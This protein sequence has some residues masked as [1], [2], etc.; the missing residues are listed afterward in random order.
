MA[1]SNSAGVQR[2]VQL[3]TAGRL[4]EAE[5]AYRSILVSNPVEPTCVNNLAALLQQKGDWAGASRLLAQ[6]FWFM[7]NHAQAIQYW[8]RVLELSPNDADT[9]VNLGAA[10]SLF[11][12]ESEAAMHFQRA[13]QIHPK[14]VFAWINLGWLMHRAGKPNEA[15]HCYK[16]ALG[17][18]PNN[19]Q[20]LSRL[21]SV[22]REA[23]EIDAA[24]EA[25][26]RAIQIEPKQVG[27]WINLGYSYLDQGD[28]KKAIE[29]FRNGLTAQ[30]NDAAARSNLLFAQ[31][32]DPQVNRQRLFEDHLEFGRIHGA[33]LGDKKPAH[34]NDRNTDRPLKIAYLS[35]D[36]RRHPVASFIEPVLRSHDRSR[37]IVS[38]YSDVRSGDE[39][40]K[41]LRGY[42][43]NWFDVATLSNEELAK[44][45][46]E[47]RED[48]L[49]D[50]A[51]H[52]A[53]GRMLTLLQKPAPVQ[54]TYLGYLNT[55]GLDTVD[56]RITD[57]VADPEPA[58]DAYYSEKLLRLPCFFCY[59][60]PE[61]APAVGSLPAL[62]AGH[63]TFGSLNQSGKFNSQVFD[64]WARLLERVPNSRLV[65]MNAS[66]HSA[67]RLL[68]QF[69]QRGVQADR[70][71]LTPKRTYR[72][73]LELYNSIDIAL[74]PFPFSGH[75]TTCDALWMGCPVI[76]RA[77]ELYASRTCASVLTHLGLSEL[78][79]NDPEQYL[80]IAIQ[81]ANDIDRLTNLRASLRQRM[82]E[83]V[84]TNAAVFTANLERELCEVWRRTCIPG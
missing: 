68:Q 59:Q 1:D 58:A 53:G 48:I 40:T 9:H 64:L 28:A 38:C 84:I 14:H 62:S 39:I 56:Y 75:T 50:L 76:T 82:R 17:I 80:Q 26:T 31:H 54:M 46:N 36:F 49:I 37:F 51:G 79:A 52:T 7:G 69:S 55:T 4:E 57:P 24:I 77:G 63:I 45:I 29:C 5:H 8:K 19:S 74:D 3:H 70:I 27:A 60:P 6:S 13:L 30:P 34:L 11:G 35:P 12:P 61:E 42:A 18:D 78:I 10:L 20:A 21:G 2:A 66:A 33:R 43:A 67:A 71:S 65:L 22:F 81:H 72:D 41:R 15:V 25:C 83:S 32:Y 16:Q 73:Y 47:N 23:Q 44:K